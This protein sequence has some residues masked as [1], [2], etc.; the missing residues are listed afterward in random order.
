MI[1]ED[2]SEFQTID[3]TPRVGTEIK[4]DLKTLLSGKYA[5]RIRALLE[6]RGVLVV[7]NVPMKDEQQ[8][9]FCQTLGE[10]D[11]QDIR[12]I[13][14]PLSIS[15]DPSQ[16]KL[17]EYFRAT[18]YWHIDRIAAPLPHLAGIM[19]PR[20]VSDVGGE[21]EFA[22]TYAAWEDLPE[23][24]KREYEGLRV[25]HALEAS[26][27]MVTPEPSLAELEGWRTE[28]A[29][30]RPLVWTHRSGR[31]SLTV[32][33][34]AL[35]VVG[36]S[37]QESRYILTKLRE[38]ATQRQYVYQ[39]KWQMGDLLI[40]DNTGLLHRALPYPIESGR[41]LRRMSLAGEEPIA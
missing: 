6:R 24:E 27:L 34:T 18:I 38:W 16:N 39:H 37:A 21:T 11:M 22:N 19:T 17:A 5:K 13:K 23:D 32:A 10:L 26:L 14:G 4:A 7:R 35:Q 3:F 1:A 12:G 31:K 33:A 25:I 8:T 15:R 20:K 41:L 2:S 9:A 30:E 36:K 29:A 40:W 28:P